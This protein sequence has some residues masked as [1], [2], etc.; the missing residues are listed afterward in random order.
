MKTIKTLIIISLLAFSITGCGKQEVEY[1]SHQTEEILEEQTAETK[2]ESFIIDLKE[3]LNVPDTCIRDIHTNLVYPKEIHIEAEV[4][5]N[6][7]KNMYVIDGVSKVYDAVEK[8]RIIESFKDKET[9]VYYADE[10]NIPKSVWDDEI[11]RVEMDIE[12]FERLGH[13]TTYSEERLQQLNAELKNAPDDYQ[14]ASTYDVDEYYVTQRGCMFKIS[15]YTN[16]DGIS[17]MLIEPVSLDA[18]TGYISGY[19]E[20]EYLGYGGGTDIF[21]ESDNL[22]GLSVDDYEEKGRTILKQLGLEGYVMESIC[23]FSYQSFSGENSWK[24]G[25]VTSWYRYVDGKRVYGE[26]R[27]SISMNKDGLISFTHYGAM[28]LQNVMTDAATMLPFDSLMTAAETEMK[29]LDLAEVLGYDQDTEQSI[30]EIDRIELVYSCYSDADNLGCMPILPTWLFIDKSTGNIK[31]SINA[32]D[33][34][35]LTEQPGKP[36]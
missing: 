18:V 36:N 3:Q 7:T 4:I 20:D 16:I 24:D 5:V 23:D 8:K 22:S 27:I 35:M 17:S 10:K 28:D 12:A 13:D 34:S 26:E 9:E 2:G 11:A 15:F 1:G 33:G 25:A 6:N 31:Y 32:I 29:K 21:S 30:V 19:G 14:I